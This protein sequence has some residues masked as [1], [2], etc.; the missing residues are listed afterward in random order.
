MKLRVFSAVLV[1]AMA[2]SSVG[3]YARPKFS[4]VTVDARNG[5]ILFSDNAD[6][7]RHPASL[8]KMMTLY[9]LF[10]EMK[11]GRL[12]RDTS[13]K[14][15]VRA[16][17]MAPTKLDLEPGTTI[18]VDEAIKALV[19][20]SAND[21]AVAIAENIAGSEGAFAKRMTMVAHSIGMTHSN[22]NNASGLPNDGQYTT[23]RDIATLGLRLMRD[24]PQYYPYF[25]TT[26][27]EFRGRTIK[28]HNMLV[29]HYP[30]TDGFKTGYV[31]N[32]GFNLA[33]STKRGDKRLVG[34]VLGAR[35][36]AIRT[37]YMK[38][39]L[40]GQFAKAH[41]G[42]TIAAL[43]GSS[44]GAINPVE[45]TD[46]G[47]P[48]GMNNLGLAA[49]AA[50][51]ATADSKAA[52]S[53]PHSPK[54]ID[55]QLEPVDT[56]R[57]PEKLP[58]AVVSANDK[59]PDIA[60]SAGDSWNVQ[61]GTFAGKPAAEDQLTNSRKKFAALF[62]GKP[63]FTMQDNK[64]GTVVYRARFG[65]FNAAT[66]AKACQALKEDGASCLMIAPES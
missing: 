5:Q 9:I 7:L 57:K 64:D 53:A 47:K 19:T 49:A 4:A 42:N 18:T 50:D 41:D 32:A 52:N 15:S 28:T 20:K 59:P 56:A 31:A 45:V 23:A 55:A 44:A 34:V 40:E 33:T 21:A 62:D 8:T 6:G 66:A 65:G 26:E 48:A 35:S 36:P 11:A 30:G 39:M 3:A 43:A 12:S 10:E 1:L 13:L 60:K 54:V 29:L 22:F 25:R 46:K 16:A 58:F 14:V 24:F 61:V 17:S 37:V 63:G 51:A 38:H 27:F 2:C